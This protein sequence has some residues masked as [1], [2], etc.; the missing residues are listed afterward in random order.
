MRVGP[1]EA[2]AV[3]TATFRLDG[4]A[5]FGI[6]PRALWEKDSPPD[7][8]NRVALALRCLL[9]QGA[10]RT[11]VIDTG[12]GDKGGA[13]FDER[14]AVTPPQ[15]APADLAPGTSRLAGALAA[16]GVQP[17][18]VTD[19]VLTHLHWD[20]AG[21]ATIPSPGGGFVPQF[22]RARYYVQREHHA[23][24]QAPSERDEGS[25]RRDDWEALG[26]RLVLLD[27][28][29]EILPGVRARL[30]GGHT[31]G[32]Q[33]VHVEDGAGAGGGGGGSGDGG[34]VYCADLVPTSH[35][36]RPS[37]VMGYDLF[38]ATGVREKRALLE[39]AVRRRW[40]LFFEHDP[41][42]DAATVR[43]DGDRPVV[44]QVFSL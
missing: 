2:R 18:D 33:L 41:D 38:P 11:I 4:G 9:L 14:F 23:W 31:P 13:R 19:C 10:G 29:G 17:E 26:E 39:E 24:A 28:P 25:F 12:I 30:S 34:L 42:V 40:I 15:A 5:M 27:G 6:V 43:W 32:L 44:D 21:G 7:A 16:L 3:R 35:H 1:Y 37:W 8:Q 22:P 20:H 36:L